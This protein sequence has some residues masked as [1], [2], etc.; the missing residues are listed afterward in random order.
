LDENYI[1][2]DSDILVYYKRGKTWLIKPNAKQLH[3]HVGYVDLTS[4]INKRY[5]DCV[6]TNKNETLWLLKPNLEDYVAKSKRKT[7]IV[8]PK[9]TGLILLKLNVFPGA[10]VIEVGVGSGGL[11]TYLSNSVRP[12]GHVHCYDINPEFA[13]NTKK[14]LERVNLLEFITIKDINKTGIDVK[15]A[16]CAMVDIGDPW[17]VVESVWEGLKG[18]GN[19]AFV[20]PTINQ[21][22]KLV[23]KLANS[24]FTHIETVEVLSRMIEAREGK[25]RPAMRMVG[26]TAYLI[27]ARKIFPLTK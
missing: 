19:I 5:G 7:Q 18:G 23:I 3:T 25:S 10:Q 15:N 20:C 8:Y 4:V 22:E 26:H 27:F 17:S 6:V 9:D 14:N 11:T 12:T 2:E 16:D 21:V 13:N 1:T 24:G